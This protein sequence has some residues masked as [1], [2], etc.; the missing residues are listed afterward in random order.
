MENQVSKPK[1]LIIGLLFAF[2]STSWGFFA[3]KEINKIAVYSLPPEL[4]SFYKKHVHFITDHAVDPDKR[5]YIL[6]QEAPK[7]YWDKEFYTDSILYR[8]TPIPYHQAVNRYSLDSIHRHGSLPW[9]LTYLILQLTQ[10]FREKEVSRIIKLSSDIGHYVGDLH[11]PLHTTK[12]YNGQL[13]HQQ[14]IHGLWESRLPEIYQE[15]YFYYVQKPDYIINKEKA[16]WDALRASN[17]AVDSVLSFE[18]KVALSLP[19]AQHFTYEERNGSTIRTYSRVF[20]QKYHVLLNGMVERRLQASVYLLA[21][22][23]YSAWMDAGSPDLN[24][25]EG[26]HLTPEEMQEQ[27]KLLQL[28]A[29]QGCIHP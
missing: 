29:S 12:N 26:V 15:T 9:N 11:V 28:P 6:P 8:S 19:A 27:Q 18:R 20:C 14:G 2:L 17:Q 5:R 3:H 23:W 13:T 21:S 10:A 16:V 1:F 22:I 25:Q 4:G 24:P 7:H